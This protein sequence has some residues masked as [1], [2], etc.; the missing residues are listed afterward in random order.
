M[1][2]NM[3][4]NLLE[5]DRL[6]NQFFNV[7][8]N[9][10]NNTPNLDDLKNIFIKEGLIISNNNGEPLIYDLENFIKPRMEILSDGTLTDFREG[11]I[12][13]KTS[14]FGNIAQRFC[15]YEKSGKLNGEYFKTEG[16]KTI[17]FIKV[18]GKWK[19]SSVAWSDKE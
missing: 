16:M 8:D 6:T 14:T 17:Q 7:F 5:I 11:E 1:E 13:H 15:L 10:N 4:K 19:M 12:S 18:R 9:T 3:E 2:S